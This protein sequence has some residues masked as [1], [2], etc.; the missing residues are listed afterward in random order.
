VKGRPQ[1]PTNVFYGLHKV[2]RDTLPRDK[3][4]FPKNIEM[5]FNHLDKLGLAG[6]SAGDLPLSF[7]STED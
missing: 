5:Y 3:L 7:S 1:F 2:E 6:V 4:T